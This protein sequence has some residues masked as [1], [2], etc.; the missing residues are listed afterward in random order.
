MV[1]KK[2]VYHPNT[3]NES[4]KE[5]IDEL[6]SALELVDQQSE[7]DSPSIAFFETIVEQKKAQDKAKLIRDL[8]LFSI[9]AVMTMIILL[10][11]LIK[12]TAVF[13]G[14]QVIAILVFPLIIIRK[15]KQAD[16]Y[17]A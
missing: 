8:V 15:R 10:G 6:Y 7:G 3:N 1:R 13:I 16:I 17:D 9:I 2:T 14:I 12:L 5:M 11:I 4:D